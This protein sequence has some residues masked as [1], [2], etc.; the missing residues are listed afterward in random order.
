MRRFS[1]GFVSDEQA[2]ISK[3]DLLLAVLICSMSHKEFIEFIEDI[4]CDSQVLKWGEKCGHFDFLEKCRLFQSYLDSSFYSPAY[5][6]TGEGGKSDGDWAQN[7]KLG[8]MIKL[9]ASEEDVLNTPL[10]SLLSDYFRIAE[11]D[12]LIRIQTVEEK[13]IA[14]NNAKL[15]EALCQA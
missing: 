7:L 13:E 8:M 10:S 6:V 12:G 1:C 14:D 3:G 4:S 2:E 9:N 11:M 15:L 5:S